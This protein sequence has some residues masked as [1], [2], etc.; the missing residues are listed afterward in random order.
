VDEIR[1]DLQDAYE[2]IASAWKNLDELESEQ[3]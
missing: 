3:G 2:S 1:S